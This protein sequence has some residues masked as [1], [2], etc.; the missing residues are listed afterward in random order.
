VSNT[1][2][3]PTLF[4]PGGLSASNTI[5]VGA[6]VNYDPL[7]QTVAPL[8]GVLDQRN[9]QYDLETSVSPTF[10][11]TV[12]PR[13][14]VPTVGGRFKVV[15][16][17]VLNFFT[18]LGSRG[19]QT[20]TEFNNQ[21]AKVLAELSGMNA[22]IYGLS[23]VQNF[24]DGN[25]GTGSNH[26]TNVA[27]QS[28]VDGLN[29]IFGAGT[30]AL[31]DTLPLGSMNGTDA[32]RCAIIYKVATVTPVGSPAEY[33]Q[34][35][36]N[37][38]TLAQTF[39]PATG[40]KAS[41]QT[42]TVA[43]NHFRSKSSACGGGS[44]DVF[45]G[46]CNGLRLNMATNVVAWLAGNPTND[47]APVA[48]RKLLVLGDFNAYYGEDPIQYF[49][50][51]GYTNLINLLIGPNAYS[52]N[53]GLQ[54]G[55]L[56][57]AMVNNALNTLVKNVAEWH[58]NADEPAALEAINSSTKPAASNYVAQDQ[59]AASDHDP[60]LI[61]LNPLGGDFDDDGAV[62]TADQALIQGAIGKTVSQVDRRMDLDGDGKIT[63]NDY[64]LW[65]TLYRAFVQ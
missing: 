31:I 35:D 17:N 61:G 3:F 16:A 12:N 64:R 60:I 53:F 43:V 57:H 32:I 20:A 1:N 49:V 52:Y 59:F 18:T 42:F 7:S 47:P 13:P 41:Q 38:P 26:Y 44:D 9:S 54:N 11:N 34:N 4:P 23:E 29:S 55:Y 58:I 46:N 24:D 50:G 2:L 21:R 22:D 28:L 33:Y 65:V 48:T 63:L 45:Q 30:Y 37:R 10:D 39:Q 8:L 5:R 62:T 27:L 6:R 15:S 51:H 40:A 19:A 25:T 14:T 36:T 56:D